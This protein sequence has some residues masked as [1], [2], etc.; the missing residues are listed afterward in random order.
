[1]KK[2][3]WRNLKTG[4]VGHAQ[5]VPEKQEQSKNFLNLKQ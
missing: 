5:W 3:N 4:D 1:M 2:F